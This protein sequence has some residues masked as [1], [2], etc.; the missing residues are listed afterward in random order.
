[1]RTDIPCEA[2]DELACGSP[3]V[4]MVW[5][6]CEFYRYPMCD[7]HAQLA[8]SENWGAATSSCT[9]TEIESIDECI[10]AS[11]GYGFEEYL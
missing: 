9:P 6:C 10:Q 2:L 5:G 11:N 4:W 1:M 8:V 7:K 3:S